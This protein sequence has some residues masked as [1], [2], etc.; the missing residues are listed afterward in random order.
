MQMPKINGTNLLCE[1]KYK[2]PFDR[3]NIERI[4]QMHKFRKKINTGVFL[5]RRMRDQRAARQL[6]LPEFDKPG[7]RDSTKALKILKIN[8]LCI[9]AVN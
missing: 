5:E 1:F 7:V 2:V 8:A 6:R 9:L 4:E 3:L